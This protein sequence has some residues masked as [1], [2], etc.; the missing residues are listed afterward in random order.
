MIYKH[1]YIQGRVRI[2]Y[3]YPLA[4]H[5]CI[6]VRVR[7]NV[8]MEETERASL[9]VQDDEELRVKAWLLF[10][11]V[12]VVYPPLTGRTRISPSL[13]RRTDRERK[14]GRRSCLGAL[15]SLRSYHSFQK[16]EVL[17]LGAFE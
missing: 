15:H 13:S 12:A 16:I 11:C 6:S 3:V 4:L 5:V 9:D 17:S 14:A 1:T 7:T 2:E 8:C 10:T